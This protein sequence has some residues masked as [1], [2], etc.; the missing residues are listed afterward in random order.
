MHQLMG[1]NNKINHTISHA[2]GSTGKAGIS[3]RHKTL[4]D[5]LR[6]KRSYKEHYAYLLDW[7]SNDRNG[8]N[9]KSPETSAQAQKLQD[10]K[11]PQFVVADSHV[12]NTFNDVLESI[13]HLDQKIERVSTNRGT[14]IKVGKTKRAGNIFT[15]LV[16]GRR[17]HRE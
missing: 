8:F 13:K 1:M 10:L 15:R 11:A 9:T 6:G 7:Y 3:P 4:A 14:R 12:K 16:D 17:F 5:N 2:V